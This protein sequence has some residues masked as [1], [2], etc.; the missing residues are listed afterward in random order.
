MLS[1]IKIRTHKLRASAILKYGS[2][3]RDTE[4]LETTQVKFL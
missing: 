2:K 3:E 4:R 1:E